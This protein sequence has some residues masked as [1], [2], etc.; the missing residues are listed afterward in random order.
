MIA[1]MNAHL[2]AID[3]DANQSLLQDT[4]QMQRHASNMCA[5]SDEAGGLLNLLQA[6]LQVSACCAR[7]SWQACSEVT[8]L[9]AMRASALSHLSSRMLPSQ[10]SLLTV[11]P[12]WARPARAPVARHHLRQHLRCHH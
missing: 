8:P 4:F 7:V 6:A 11:I 2:H 3:D 10:A 12:F 1:N 9:A 5:H